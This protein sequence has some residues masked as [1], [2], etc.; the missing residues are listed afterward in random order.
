MK[1]EQYYIV[2]ANQ[3]GVFFGQIKDRNGSEAT[4]TNARKLHYWSGAA[5]VE[6][7]AIEGVKNKKDCRFT[8]TVPEVTILGI[9]QFLPCTDNA[10]ENLKSVP[11]WKI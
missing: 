8:I 2:R 6:Q 11:E 10:V 9:C 7:I 5:A 3:A 4:L 1:K